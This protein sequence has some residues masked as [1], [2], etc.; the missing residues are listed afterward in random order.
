MN[1]RAECIR[2]KGGWGGGGGRRLGAFR[3]GDSLLAAGGRFA[4]CRPRARCLVC[5]ADC[6]ERP[7]T[8][9]H[10]LAGVF[11]RLVAGR[12]AAGGWRRLAAA[13]GG[14]QFGA[15]VRGGG[16]RVIPTLAVA[17]QLSSRNRGRSE[18]RGGDRRPGSRLD[19]Q[20]GTR[21]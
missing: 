11:G 3:G 1:K 4:G 16:G 15:A 6:S 7:R 12:A 21:E 14:W 5:G 9:A 10:L 2:G 20:P 19:R 18:I 13:G 8:V 17:P